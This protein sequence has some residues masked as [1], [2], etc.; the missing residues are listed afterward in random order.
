MA[1]HPPADRRRRFIAALAGTSAAAI[2]RTAHGQAA[3]G[4][5]AA[6]AATSAT[7]S[8]PERPLKLVVPFP[9]GALTDAIGRLIADRLR[10]ALG[11]QVVVENRPGA[12]TLLAGSQVAKSAPDGYTLMVATSTTLGIAPALYANPP[13]RIDELT[14]VAMIGAVTLLLVTRAEYPVSDVAGLVKLMRS[15][16]GALNFASP[17]NGTVHHLV[18][19]TLKTREK[20]YAV[21][22]P[23]QGSVPALTDVMAGRVDFMLIDAAVVMPQLRAGRVKA[24]A[25]TGTRRSPLVPDV[26]SFGELYPG[27]DLQAW[28][29]IA[30]PSGTPAPIVAR[31]NADINKALALAE[32]RAQLQQMG[33]E[34]IVM[35]VAEFNELVRR[36]AAR[37][38]EAVERSGARVD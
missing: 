6:S 4:T 37:W 35:T 12:G 21:H 2:A 24:L 28:Q 33:V 10:P 20:V 18:V 29:S 1:L 36:D 5:G 22:I 16:P 13:M 31:L 8:W 15:R 27:L 38:A 23:Y 19:E 25:V 9:P 34:P 17:G 26:P 14:G 3:S 11:Q 30:A 32:V 7:G